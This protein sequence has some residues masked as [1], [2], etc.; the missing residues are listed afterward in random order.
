[1]VAPSPIE[2]QDNVVAPSPI[3]PQDNVVAPS[4]IEPQDNVVVPS[5]IDTE[6]P[7]IA[8][9]H[10]AGA[11]LQEA[12]DQQV[13]DFLA[14]T[15]AL[16]APEASLSDWDRASTKTRRRSRPRRVPR[17]SYSGQE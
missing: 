12:S 10:S 7:I 16:T 15:M 13:D 11:S 1:M 14:E 17:K 8:R 2:P 9:N 5:P 4:P 6:V 3:E